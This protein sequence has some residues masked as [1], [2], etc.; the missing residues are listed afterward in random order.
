MRVNPRYATGLLLAVASVVWWAVGMA[1]LQPLTEPAGPWSEV[2]PGNHTY[3]AREVRLTALV[4]IVLGLVLAFGG[5]RSA[6]RA[7]LALGPGWLLADL[8]VDRADLAGWRYVPPLAAVGCLVLA[9]AVTLLR[10]RLSVPPDRPPAR[11]TLLVAATVAAVLAA[12]G[13]AVE[14]PTD[15]EP[16]LRWAGVGTGA[17]MLALACGCALAATAGSAR[18]RAGLAAGLASIGAVTVVGVRLTPPDQAIRAVWAGGVLLVTAVAVLA[19]ARPEGRSVVSWY[20]GVAAVTGVGLP[21]VLLATDLVQT[22]LPVG[23]VLTRLS[24]NI[25]LSAADTDTLV[26]LDGLVTGLVLGTLSARLAARR[27]AAA[28][29]V[30][31]R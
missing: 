18:P 26:T 7:A 15:R 21:V 3:W 28:S 24:G 22:W 16:Q 17:L 8:A 2:L 27:P 14:S 29:P 19:D 30:V 20:A 9:G 6:T 10:R 23:P 12:L 4:G 25:T 5:G 13:A 31:F 11:R 1:V